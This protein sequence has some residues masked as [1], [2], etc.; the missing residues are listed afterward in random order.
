[1]LLQSRR[2]SMLAAR[3]EQTDAAVNRGGLAPRRRERGGERMR[4]RSQVRRARP[5]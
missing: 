5:L 2:F 3:A 1:V 4:E